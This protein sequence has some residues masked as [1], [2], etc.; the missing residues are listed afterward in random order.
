[1]S[2]WIPFRLGFLAPVFSCANIGR[3]CLFF[4][5]GC[6]WRVSEDH[7]TKN[8]SQHESA[9]FF[10]RTQKD[11]DGGEMDSVSISS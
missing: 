11:A 1:M 2:S 6:I 8:V 4:C 5:C 10:F 7:I 3:I 9:V